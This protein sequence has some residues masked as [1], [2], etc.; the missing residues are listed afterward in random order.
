M[1][2]T[3]PETVVFSIRLPADMVKD[4]DQL[5]TNL[6]KEHSNL[7][8]SRNRLIQSAVQEFLKS[9]QQELA[10]KPGKTYT[11]KMKGDQ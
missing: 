9:S 5:I 2:P 7:T 1:K 8:T 10:V 3:P 6:R 4:L 11:L